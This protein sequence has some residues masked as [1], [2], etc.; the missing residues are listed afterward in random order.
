LRAQ[1]E[2]LR[3]A[4]SSSQPAPAPGD[5]GAGTGSPPRSRRPGKVRVVGAVQAPPGEIPTEAEIPRM[6]PPPATGE[7]STETARALL[8]AYVNGATP[9]THAPMPYAQIPYL[10]HFFQQGTS[11]TVPASVTTAGTTDPEAI[12]ALAS[13]LLDLT[14]DI[15]LAQA[16]IEESKALASRNMVPKS[17]LARDVAK[18]RNLEQKRKI[19]RGLVDGEI[20]ATESEVAWLSRSMGKADKHERLTWEIQLMRATARL[21]ALRAAR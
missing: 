17:E 10:N 2:D 18:L 11:Q 7:G 4:L 3:A 21:E 6:A 12:V 1:I 13:R 9:G 5:T 14:M 16:Q 19:V 20:R 15:E 8:D